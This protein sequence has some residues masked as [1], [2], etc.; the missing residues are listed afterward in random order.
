MRR[1][2]LI[3]D[4][5]F[6]AIVVPGMMF[7]F[8]TGE[9]LQWHAG[10]VLAYVLWIYALL[11]L[12]RKGL[13]PLILQGWKGVLTVVGI[14]FLSAVVTFLLSLTPVD[15]PNETAEMS[16]H[17]RAMWILFLAV[18]SYGVPVGMLSAKI[19]ELS[20]IKEEEEEAQ[21]ARNAL[22]SRASEA[23]AGQE[24]QVK[25]SYK[26]VHIPLS[27]IR[28]IEGRNN[29]ACFHLDHMNDVVSQITLKS[30]LEMLPKGKFIRVHRSFIVPLWRIEKRSMGAV[31]IMGVEEP[32][33]V[34]RS[35]KDQLDNV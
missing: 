4:I 3:L 27:A 19:K 17:L 25:S 35:Y 26:T 13:G 21:N 29:Y 7:L 16:L 30:V 10:Y 33:P 2:I 31:S 11:L 32:L 1:T 23:F 5:I 22:E 18:I 20:H 15:F 9:W 24:I 6:C 34:G 8:P 28:Y 12:S 14:I